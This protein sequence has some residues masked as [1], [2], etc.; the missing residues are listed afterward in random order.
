MD[1]QRPP[2][3]NPAAEKAFLGGLLADNRLYERVGEFLRAEHFAVAPHRRIY[4]V[5]EALIQ[6]GQRADPVTV[7]TV[8]ER[9]ECLA[10]VGGADYLADLVTAAAPISN[11][12][13]YARI[14]HDLSLKARLI[15]MGDGLRDRGHDTDV[16]VTA[17]T[18]IEEVQA[19]FS[20][21][22]EEAIPDARADAGIDRTVAMMEAAIKRGGDLAGLSCGFRDLDE[23]LGGLVA[24]DLVL[25]AARPSMGKTALATSIAMNVAKDAATAAFYSLEMTEEQLRMRVISDMSGVQMEEIRR[26]S[27]HFPGNSDAAFHAANQLRAI[28]ILVIDT[29]GMTAAGVRVRSQGIKR[30]RGLSLIVVDHL[31]FVRPADP[32]A[33]R[34][35]QLGQITQDL[36]ALAKDLQVPVLLVSQLSRALESRD[37]KRPTLSDLRDSGEIEENADVVM[38]LYREAYYVEKNAPR[39]TLGMTDESWRQACMENDDKLSEI[40]H[41]A[42]V[43]VAKHRNGP[44]GTIRLH[45][46]GSLMRFRDAE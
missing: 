15:E 25:C 23:K 33:P 4:E 10:D 46:D 2:P 11:A 3:S 26:G 18:L 22:T 7:K 8:F 24:G 45:F 19:E 32:R 30:K 14:I 39:R 41:D 27:Y 9:D 37:D 35:H 29:P 34:H 6:R 21:I 16:D 44:T 1:P 36:K 17:A 28:P 20:A 5:A 31:R 38:F 42:E 13:E 40:R 43:I 12:S